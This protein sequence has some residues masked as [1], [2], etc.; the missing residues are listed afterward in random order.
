MAIDWLARLNLG[1]HTVHPVQG[2]RTWGTAPAALHDQPLGCGNASRPQGSAG[3]G[4]PTATE[5]LRILGYPLLQTATFLLYPPS[6]CRR[7]EG[8]ALEITRECAAFNTSMAGSRSL[9]RRSKRDQ[10]SGSRNSAMYRPCARNPGEGQRRCA[11]TRA[12]RSSSRMPGSPWRIRDLVVRPISKGT[13]LP[14]CRAG[15][16]LRQRRRSGTRWPQVSKSLR[17]HDRPARRHRFHRR[18]LKAMQTDPARVRRT[19]PSDPD[20]CPVGISKVYSNAR[21]QAWVATGLP[22]RGIGLFGLQGAADREDRRGSCPVYRSGPRS[23]RRI[24]KLYGVSSAKGASGRA[25][26]RGIPSMRFVKPWDEL[27]MK[28]QLTSCKTPRQ[29]PRRS[30][31]PGAGRNA[32]RD[33]GGSQSPK[34]RATCTSPQALEV[35]LEAFEGRSTCCCI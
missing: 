35:F 7:R 29:S 28:P 6:T 12:R 22:Q 13:A 20:K 32:V 19:D 16:L 33:G 31:R 2:A 11:R 27:P 3:P 25:L 18:K 23:S 21:T 17:Q 30:P 8:A 10:E 26:R 4:W 34:C 14:Y 5:H 9:N 15:G 24:L 1:S